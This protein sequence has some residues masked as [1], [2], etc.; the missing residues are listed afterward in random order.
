MP[1]HT[2]APASKAPRV[3]DTVSSVLPE[4]ESANTKVRGPMNAAA[5]IATSSPAAGTLT[6]RAV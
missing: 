2:L 5:P 4:Y 3:I 6:A 1:D